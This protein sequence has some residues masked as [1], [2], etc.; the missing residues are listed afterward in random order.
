MFNVSE[1]EKKASVKIAD[2]DLSDCLQLLLTNEQQEPYRRTT[3]TQKDNPL[4]IVIDNHS[5][6]KCM[7]KCY[8]RDK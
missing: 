3:T 4:C 8:T 5:I 1:L 6:T 7:D 2:Q